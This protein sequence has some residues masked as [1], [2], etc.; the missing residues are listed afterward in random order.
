[1]WTVWFGE[2]LTFEV[3]RKGPPR[4]GPLMYTNE[5][6]NWCEV[7]LAVLDKDIKDPEDRDRLG[8]PPLNRRGANRDIAREQ[9]RMDLLGAA[10]T[11]N[12]ARGRPAPAKAATAAPAKAQADAPAKAATAAPVKAAPAKAAAAK[13][14][15]KRKAAQL[16]ANDTLGDTPS[17]GGEV[18]SSGGTPTKEGHGAGVLKGGWVVSVNNG[19]PLTRGNGLR[20]TFPNNYRNP[21]NTNRWRGHKLDLGQAFK[22][23]C[24]VHYGPRMPYDKSGDFETRKALFR[25]AAYYAMSPDE[26]VECMTNHEFADFL[27]ILVCTSKQM[28]YII[29]TEGRI[30]FGD[31]VFTTLRASPAFQREYFASATHDSQYTQHN[32]LSLLILNITHNTHYTIYTA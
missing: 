11:G 13:A 4:K 6:I 14:S 20:R 5:E 17:E 25:T 27:H 19:R 2:D 23:A 8:L 28:K 7:R 26:A 30:F 29:L 3:L 1:M 16:D 12:V 24:F 21:A 31:Q 32:L 9:E 22:L 10:A 18:A 15:R